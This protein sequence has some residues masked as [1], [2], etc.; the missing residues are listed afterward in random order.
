MRRELL[1]IVA[2]GQ[3]RE[4]ELEALCV[5]APANADGSWTAKDQLAHVVYWRLRNARRL[6][7]VRT[8]G[9]LPPSVEDDEQNTIVYA[10]NRDRPLAVLK[11]EAVDSWLAMRTFVEASTEEDLR[12]PHPYAADNELWETV[13][14]DIAHLDAH[15]VSLYLEAGDQSRAEAVQ[16]WHYRLERDVFSEPA[17]RAYGA[18][19]LACF[20]ARVGRAD[21]ALPLLR[22]SLEAKPELVAHAR[23]DPDLDPIR[24]HPEMVRLLAT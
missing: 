24:D 6:D 13:S 15:L 4:A 14:G 10:D 22:E 23:Q 21:E 11:A 9:E 19:N 7:A 18:Y 12:R 3:E 17:Q 5:D 16:V 2:A 1:Q 20:Y 8:G